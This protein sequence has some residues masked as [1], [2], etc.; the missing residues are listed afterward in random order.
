MPESVF[1]ARVQCKRILEIV[2]TTNFIISDL[3]SDITEEELREFFGGRGNQVEEIELNREGNADKVTAVVKMNVDNATAQ[4]MADRA[5]L[6]TWRG[7]KITI[8][9]PLPRA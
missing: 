8:H 5:K 4:I 7:R 2:M 1:D 6:R 9:V 3:P